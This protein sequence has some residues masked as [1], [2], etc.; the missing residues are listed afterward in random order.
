MKHYDYSRGLKAPYSIQVISSPKGK[1]LWVF[2]QPLNMSYLLMLFFLLFVTG[3]FWYKV[4]IPN[5]AG[6][7][8]NLLLMLSVPHKV[9]RWYSEAELDGKSTNLFLKDFIVYL[10]NFVVDQRPIIA[11]ERVDQL[12]E[13]SFKR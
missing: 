12:E 1:A 7:N 13:F 8:L 10:K 3:V 2:A 5:I 4:R 6:I 11:F 9:A